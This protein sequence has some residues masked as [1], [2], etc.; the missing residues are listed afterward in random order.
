[1]FEAAEVGSKISKAAYKEEVPKLRAELLEAQL[2]VAGSSLAPVVIVGGVEGVGKGEVMNRLLEWLDARGVE[3]YAFGDPTDEEGERPPAWR[4]WRALPARGK[5]AVLLGSW[6][7]DPIVDRVFGRIDE[8]AFEREMRRISDQEQMLHSEGVPVVKFWLHLAKKLHSKRLRKVLDDPER[9]WMVSK[10]TLKYVKRY[11][12]FREVS[13]AAIRLTS[14]GVA[15]WFV[16]E[17]ADDRYRDVTVGTILARSLRSALA[18]AAQGESGDE[19]RTPALPK[20]RKVN[21]IRQ[22]DLG[23][24]LEYEDYRKKRNRYQLRLGRLARELYETP[25]SMILVFEGPDAAGKGGTI[26]RITQSMDSR[27]YRVISVGAPTD[28]ESAHPY[29]WRFWRNLPRQGHVTVYDRSWY[30]RVLVE[31]IEGFAEREEWRRAYAEINDFEDQL[32][33]SGTVV[34]KFWLAIS[35]EEQLRRFE[36]RRVTPYK[37][38]KLTEEDWR[39][40]EKWDAYEAAACDMIERTSSE[41]APWILVESNDKRWARV[42]VLK[43]VA[44]HLKR[45]LEP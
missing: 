9:K 4:F 23:K 36:K 3:A 31:R 20:P 26:R 33:E 10:R 38:Y 22:L 37:Q 1:M 29:L 19:K 6:Y 15:P 32:T 43:T 11:D 14:T 21:I 45:A 2:E 34:L 28:E 5:M 35:A 17:A 16:V 24:T 7:T 39:N 25:H 18:G 40:R 13:E 42:K 27:Q 41:Q 8:M 12:E 30:G 44:D